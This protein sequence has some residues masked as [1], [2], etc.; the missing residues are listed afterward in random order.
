M[1]SLRRLLFFIYMSSTIGT[2]TELSAVNSILGSIGQAPLTQLD[3][4]NPEHSYVFNILREARIDVLNEGWHFNREENVTL[5]PQTSSNYILYPAD[6][7]RVDVTGNQFDRTTDVVKREGKLYDK[8]NKT[9]TF[10]K[11]I[12]ADIVRAYD[13]EDIPSVYQ[14]YITY[15]AATRAATR[16]ATREHTTATGPAEPGSTQGNPRR[17]LRQNASWKS[18]ESNIGGTSLNFHRNFTF[19][20]L[21]R[22]HSTI[23]RL[24]SCNVASFVFTFFCIGRDVKENCFITTT[25]QQ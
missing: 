19:W 12:K 3:Y 4:T 14:R 25:V 24:N 18:W 21:D 13:F 6:A 7:L 9:Y 2:D 15:R 22:E 23:F 16:G 5:S 8:V 17:A 10:T 1:E 20:C 11:S